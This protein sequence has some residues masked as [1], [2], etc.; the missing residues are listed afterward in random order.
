MATTHAQDHDDLADAINKIEAEL[1]INPSGAFATVAARLAAS[2]ARPGIIFAEDYGVVADNLTNNDAALDAAYDALPDAGGVIIIP[3]RDAATQAVRFNTGKDW[4]A[5]PVRIDGQAGRSRGVGDLIGGPNLRYNGSGAVGTVG[6]KLG[7]QG[8]LGSIAYHGGAAEIG[9]EWITGASGGGA[10]WGALPGSKITGGGAFGCHIANGVGTG[11][12]MGTRLYG[13]DAS[14]PTV[15]WIE[16]DDV[17]LTIC[18]IGK[19]NPGLQLAAGGFVMTGGDISGEISGANGIKGQLWITAGNHSLFNGTRFGKHYGNGVLGDSAQ[20]TVE[21]VD[22]NISYVRFADCQW[23]NNTGGT[24]DGKVDALRIIDGTGGVDRVVVSGGHMRSFNTTDEYRYALDRQGGTRVIFKPDIVENCDAGLWP[25]GGRPDVVGEF[26]ATR[27]ANQTAQRNTKVGRNSTSAGTGAA[28]AETDL[29]TVTMTRG[30]IGVG[31]SLRVVAAGTISGVANTK[32][33]RLK[34]GATTLA[35]ISVVAGA[36]PDW[37]FEATI[38]GT[39]TAA[40]RIFVRA[41]EGATLEVVDYLTATENTT[42][43]DI[44]VKVTGQT[45]DAGDEI[46]ATMLEVTSLS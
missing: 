10:E 34:L 36:T 6:L 41:F 16:E 19:G 44:V 38:I 1:G 5:K 25:A 33:V 27:I 35:T 7:H 30:I 14:L 8:I 32:T 23:T 45:A 29:Q 24:N 22:G 26:I 20:V 21:G 42:T 28:T 13:D 39:G 46:T 18:Y 31:G 40:Q 43:A 3:G 11:E 37:G 4:T 12:L 9:F 17:W 15:L 2:M